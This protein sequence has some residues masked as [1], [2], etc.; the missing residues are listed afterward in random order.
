MKFVRTV[1]E[2]TSNWSDMLE[3]AWEILPMGG[4]DTVAVL[5]LFIPYSLV[6]LLGMV[7]EE[8]D[9]D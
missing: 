5:I 7:P 4:W 6:C 9:D 8:L 1:D 3:A 2:Y